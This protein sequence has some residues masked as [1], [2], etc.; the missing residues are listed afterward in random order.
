QVVNLSK[1]IDVQRLHTETTTE[2]TKEEESTSYEVDSCAVPLSEER[3][4]REK[5]DLPFSFD[6]LPTASSSP[7]LPLQTDGPVLAPSPGPEAA[8][9][10]VSPPLPPAPVS[11]SRNSNGRA[12]AR[13]VRESQPWPED[14]RFV[15]EFLARQKYLAPWYDATV[16]SRLDDYAWW[17][18]LSVAVNGLDTETLDREFAKMA[19]WIRDHPNRVPTARGLRKFIG[20]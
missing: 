9:V 4:E 11:H 1:C 7:A 3:V 14:G 13:P 19:R 12:H 16:L 2:T 17:E 6:S 8:G 5:A 10:G 20:D 15:Q 18:N